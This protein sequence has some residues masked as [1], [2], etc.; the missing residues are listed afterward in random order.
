MKNLNLVQVM[1]QFIR[2]S[3]DNVHTALPAVILDYDYKKQKAKVKPQVNKKFDDGIEL[4][5]PVITGVPVIFPRAGGASLSFPV[6]KG[7]TVLVL[8]SER[9]LDEWLVK[10]KEVTPEDSRRFDLTDA[11]AI[12]GLLPFTEKSFA[13]NN[14]DVLLKY[15]HAEFRITKNKKFTI[16]NQHAEL[17]DTINQLLSAIENSFVPT[18][19]G[20]QKLSEVLNL[21]V[22][23]IKSKLGMLKG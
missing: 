4:E 19:S 9:S 3:M 11:I 17:L 13:D 21:N 12:P 10:G 1:S 23:T 7:D 8:F 18:V 6:K 5:L 22:S 16:K 2:A 14:D 15:G 20:P